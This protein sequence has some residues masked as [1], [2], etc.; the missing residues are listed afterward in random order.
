[1]ACEDVAAL[2]PLVLR[3]RPSAVEV[4]D[5]F[6]LDH[7]KESAALD[8]LRRSILQTDPGALLCVELYGDRAEDLPPRLEALERALAASG[9]RCQWRRAAIAPAHGESLPG[10]C[11]RVSIRAQRS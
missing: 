9:I 4:M 6:I 7:A 1:M 8:A 5:R 10:T 2:A 11:D 3:H